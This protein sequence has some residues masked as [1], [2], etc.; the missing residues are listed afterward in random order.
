[1]TFF[2][3]IRKGNV[4]VSLG[5][6][7]KMVSGGLLGPMGKSSELRPFQGFQEGGQIISVP[8]ETQAGMITR[9][10][11]GMRPEIHIH[12]NAIDTQNA[13]DFIVKHGETIANQ[14]SRLWTE[15]HPSRKGR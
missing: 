13:H 1:V 4:P 9:G 15:N 12:V 6:L 3:E 14:M 7:S 11:G 8:S 5:H 10:E 2:E